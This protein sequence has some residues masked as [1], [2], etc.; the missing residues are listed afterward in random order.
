MMVSAKKW[1]QWTHFRTLWKPER[2]TI[3][4]ILDIG[5]IVISFGWNSIGMGKRRGYKIED[6]LLVCH[7]PGHNDT[8][9]MV[10][11]KISYQQPLFGVP[12]DKSLVANG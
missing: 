6:I 11:R 3:H 5:G 7:G 8:I 9:C 4:Q 2:D 1:E 10:E 12:A